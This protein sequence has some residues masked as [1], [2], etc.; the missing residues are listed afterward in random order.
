M[1]ATIPA[2]LLPWLLFAA[3]LSQRPRFAVPTRSQHTTPPRRRRIPPSRT[4]STPNTA[5]TANTANRA[6]S[7]SP[8]SRASAISLLET[9][10]CEGIFAVVAHVVGG[11][12]TVGPAQEFERSDCEA[13]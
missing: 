12:C 1:R 3:L 10:E 11:G 6:N 8:L 5:N 9:E 7:E 4:P 13:A 2:V